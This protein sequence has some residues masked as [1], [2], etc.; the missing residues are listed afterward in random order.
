MTYLF[1]KLFYGSRY[2][3]SGVYVI[4]LEHSAVGKIKT[5]VFAFL[6]T[7]VSA[8]QGYKIRGGALEVGR[9]STTAVIHSSILIIL[10]NLILTQLLLT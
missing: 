4:I 10:F 1:A 9:S 8:Y 5:V 7:S 6:I 2:A 3:A